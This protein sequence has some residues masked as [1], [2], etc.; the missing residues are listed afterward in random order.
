MSL[1]IDIH[2]LLNGRV[3]EWDRL[4]FKTGW[5]PEDV[6][7]TMCAFANDM[8]NWGGGYIIIG[9]KEING[10]PQFPAVGLQDNQIDR[11]QKELVSLCQQMEPKYIPVTEPVIYQDKLLFI[12]WVAGGDKRPYKAPV[13]LCKKE[14]KRVYIRQGF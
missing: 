9:V 11:I 3:I 4:E 12:I 14:Q 7:H 8:N 2:K 10:I 1:P 5:N 13:N 6:V